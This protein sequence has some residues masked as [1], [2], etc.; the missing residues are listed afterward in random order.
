MRTQ[1]RFPG[2]KFHVSLDGHTFPTVSNLSTNIPSPTWLFVSK[3]RRCDFYNRKFVRKG[4]ALTLSLEI[5]LSCIE[6]TQE[7]TWAGVTEQLVYYF[8]GALVQIE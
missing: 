2:S 3:M 4:A 8:L 5:C 6:K 1:C 7:E